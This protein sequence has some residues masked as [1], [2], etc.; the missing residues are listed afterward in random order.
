MPHHNELVLTTFWNILDIAVICSRTV[1]TGSDGFDIQWCF[2]TL[3]LFNMFRQQSLLYN[4]GRGID[5]V[6]PRMSLITRPQHCVTYFKTGSSVL[7]TSLMWLKL[8]EYLKNTKT[9]SSFQFLNGGL[10]EFWVNFDLTCVL[11]NLTLNALHLCV[12]MYPIC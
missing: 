7:R 1:W 12:R 4:K 10:F 6:R 9:D 5:I 8:K 3:N 2:R 11:F